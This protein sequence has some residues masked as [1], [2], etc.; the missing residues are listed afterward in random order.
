MRTFLFALVLVH[1]FA[2]STGKSDEGAPGVL[3]I[4]GEKAVI[5]RQTKSPDGHYAFAWIPKEKDSVD[6]DLLINNLGAFYEKYDAAEVW[7]VDLQQARKLDTV[8]SSN[9]YIRPG[10][11]R[12]LAA[13][14]GPPN[15]SGRRFALASSEWKWGTD[16]L[17]L[18]DAGPQDARHVVI[19]PQVDAF[20]AASLKQT[21][22]QAKA[23]LNI[24]YAVG[25]LPEHGT[26]TGFANATTVLLPYT[27]R[28]ELRV[29]GEGVITIKLSR[30][31]GVPSALVTQVTHGEAEAEPFVDNA[32]LA[33][34]D[35]EL[36]AVYSQLIKRL[37][38]AKRDQLREEQRTWIVARDHQ[39]A[40]APADAGANQRVARDRVLTELT[41]Q[42]TAELRKMLQAAGK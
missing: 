23:A 8:V 22:A 1:I 7:A 20:V 11:H 40:E 4:G 17:Y 32:Q 27:A 25:G 39:A 26:K 38:P 30:S 16:I 14:W 24:T 5:A 37:S 15:D 3:T 10:T 2:V 13:A 35:A 33:K 34:A 31:G 42:R 18:L 9:S 12:S 6:W 36:N 28:N 19:G 29:L 41:E 21:S